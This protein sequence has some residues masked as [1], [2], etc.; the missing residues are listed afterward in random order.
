MKKTFKNKRRKVFHNE[1][2]FQTLIKDSE[3]KLLERLTTSLQ[4]STLEAKQH[5]IS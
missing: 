1:K 5:D 3:Q 4:K 2:V